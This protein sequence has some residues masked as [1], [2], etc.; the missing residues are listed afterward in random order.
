VTLECIDRWRTL[1]ELAG[2]VTPFTEKLESEIRAEVAAEHQAELEEQKKAAATELAEIRQK[3]Q[4]E[5]ATKLRSRLLE[6]A[7]RRRG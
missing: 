3:T 5:I 7:T 6:L 4:A 1:Q 2:I